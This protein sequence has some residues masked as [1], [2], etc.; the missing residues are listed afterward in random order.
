[1]RLIIEEVTAIDTNYD[2]Q[3]EVV[4]AYTLWCK[5]EKRSFLR[6]RMDLKMAILLY[7]T[8]KYNESLD[9]LQSLIYEVKKLEDKQLLV[10]ISLFES[11]LFYSIHNIPKAK[12]SLTNARSLATSIYIAPLLQAQIDLQAGILQ[13]EEGDYRTAYSYFLEAFEAFEQLDNPAKT[14]ALQYLLLTK[15]LNKQGS[16][17]PGLVQGKFNAKYGGIML[18]AMREVALSYSKK[19]LSEY[20]DVLQ[21]ISFFSFFS[22]Y[23]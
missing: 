8:S 4:K 18:E 1:M 22:N 23:F 17:V 7:K 2:K 19:S 15:I 11:Q 16:E 12:S 6:Q 14:K 20:R 5:E 10:E 21:K 3:I 13:T 9:L